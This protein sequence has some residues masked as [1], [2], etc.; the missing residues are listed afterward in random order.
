MHDLITIALP[1]YNHAHYLPQAIRSILSQDY[2]RFELFIVDDGS[3][4]HSLEILREW[5]EKD[6]R[7]KLILHKK[8]RGIFF[9]VNE[10][11]DA[12][13]GAYFH[14]LGADDFYLPGFLKSCLP[15]LLKHPTIP[16]TACES[17]SYTTNPNEIHSYPLIQHNHYHLMTPQAA[18]KKLQY[19]SLKFTGTNCIMKTSLMRDS[20]GYIEKFNASCDWFMLTKVA[21]SYG[22]IYIPSPLVCWKR[23]PSGV[24]A[25]ILHDRRGRKKMYSH[26]LED[27]AT[28]P[29][30][31]FNHFKLSGELGCVLK[32]APTELFKR[33]KF[34]PFL[35]KM[36]GRF[37]RRKY[38]NTFFKKGVADGAVDPDVGTQKSL[39]KLQYNQHDQ[40]RDE[41]IH[42]P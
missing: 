8:N 38:R 19:T 35:P 20:G 17:Y 28:A 13:Q 36:I 26:V 10:V 42:I 3:T 24:S 29:P 5:S 4:D 6:G 37:L 12:A 41:E 22:A 39:I 11:L 2:D 23:N 31:L 21:L 9:S 14:V 16:M 33:P 30:K 1:N 27:L 32:F 40:Q 34:W 25:T 18:A 15:L 7:I